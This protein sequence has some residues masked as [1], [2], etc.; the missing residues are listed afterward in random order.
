MHE[1][2]DAVFKVDAD[3]NIDHEDTFAGIFRGAKII[4]DK[5]IEPKVLDLVQ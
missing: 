5:Y 2:G 4:G 3:N 1:L